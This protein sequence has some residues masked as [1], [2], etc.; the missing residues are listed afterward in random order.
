MNQCV[1]LKKLADKGHIDSMLMY[2]SQSIY[3]ADTQEKKR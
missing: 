1:Y 3:H 2:A